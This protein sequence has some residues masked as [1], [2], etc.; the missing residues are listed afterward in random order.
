MRP[1]R[2]RC[3]LLLEGD[4]ESRPVDPH[5]VL[6]GELDRQVDGEAVGVVEPERHVTRQHR[7]IVGQAVGEPTDDPLRAGERDERL[8]EMDGARIERPGEGGLLAQDARPGSRS[9][10]RA[11]WGTRH[12]WTR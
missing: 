9:G 12:P 11:G 4:L 2:D 1:E 7:G 8:L 3:A 10:A 6:A 5:P